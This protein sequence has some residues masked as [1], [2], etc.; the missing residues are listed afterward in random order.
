MIMTPYRRGI[1][2]GIADLPKVAPAQYTPR[3]AGIF[4][5]GW[6]EGQQRRRRA[7]REVVKWLRG[8]VR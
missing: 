7:W 3:Y 8:A 1:A 5:E 4:I 2:A 6:D